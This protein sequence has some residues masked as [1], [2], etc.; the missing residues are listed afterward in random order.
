M[1][2]TVSFGIIKGNGSGKVKPIVFPTGLMYV[3]SLGKNYVQVEVIEQ[4]PEQYHPYA[5]REF[6]IEGDKVPSGRVQGVLLTEGGRH[7]IA[8][9]H[10]DKETGK[11]VVTWENGSGQ[12]GKEV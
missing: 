2:F 5:G 6:I 3:R 9:G 11:P 12:C 1:C 4:M 8:K 7:Q 10:F